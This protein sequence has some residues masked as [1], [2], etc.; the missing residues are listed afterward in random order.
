MGI[1]EIMGR[2][3]LPMSFCRCTTIAL[4]ALWGCS[5]S[6]ARGPA[7]APTPRV[8]TYTKDV[9]PIIFERCAAC[10]SPA[11]S[12]PLP[13]LDYADVHAR[14]KLIARVVRAGVMPPW[15]PDEGHGEF[16]GNRRLSQQQIDTIERWVAQ[17]AVHGDIADLPPRPQLSQ[18]WRLGTPDLVVKMPR[19]Y[20]LP[21]NDKAPR[22]AR[23][24]KHLAS[25]VWR[26]FVIPIPISRAAYVRT[27][28][29]LPGSPRFVHHGTLAIDEMRSSRRRDAQDAEV[30]FAGMDMGEV[31]EPDGALLGWTPG[32]QPFSGIDGIAW[33]LRPGSD[34][35]LQLHMMPSEAPETIEAQIGFYFAR[36][37]RPARSA[38]VVQLNGDEQLNIPAGVSAFTVS[39]S[40]VVPVDVELYAV[41]PHAHYI[42]KSVEAW[43]T[44]PDGSV[45]S[46][47]KISHW[48]F[49]WQ[50]VYRYTAPV[51]LPRGTTVVMRWTYDNSENNLRQVNRPPIMV[52]AGNRSS[53]E[54]AHLQIQMG[55]RNDEDLLL[56]KEVDARHRLRVAPRNVWFLSGLAAVLKDQGRFAEAAGAYQAA[57]ESDPRYVQAH[58]NL[59]AVLMA[60]EQPDDAIRHLLAALALDSTNAVAHYNL[61]FALS[62]RGRLDEAVRH[63]RAA[64]QQQPDFAEVH[65][66]LGQVLLAQGRVDEALQHFR[67][68]VRLL[69]DSAD[70]HNNLGSALKRRGRLTE[71]VAEFRKALA[72]DPSHTDARQNMS[73][74]SEERDPPRR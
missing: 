20:T 72:L 45:R 54:M 8:L 26:N 51:S 11:G 29:I 23:E 38:Y 24:H 4:A 14:A 48:D 33:R 42:G 18:G 68:A 13:L 41:Y 15:L 46:L 57:L 21:A 73:R 25:D 5:G 7:D 65:N 17:G 19:P 36:D 31:Q 61:G 37:A 30:G 6:S 39:D 35:V 47:L 58:I 43:A 53:D 44:L 27:V 32:M 22:T 74:V 69:P 64:L 67:D 49:K 55:V 1:M 10:H 12:A 28:E 34:A 70:V 63:Y 52:R 9:A 40:L 2:M 66:N 50:D 3:E 56:L 60:L 62:S 59:S 16:A 71:S